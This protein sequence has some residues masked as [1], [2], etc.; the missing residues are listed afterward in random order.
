MVNNSKVVAITPAYNL[1]SSIE[2]TVKEM[3]EYCDEVIV[4]SD[5]STDKTNENARKTKAIV[6]DEKNIRG[7]GNAVIR[8]IEYSKKLNPAYIILIDADGQHLP[9]EIPLFLKKLIEENADMV[10]GSRMKGT[11]KTSTINKIGNFGLKM[12]SFFVSG[13]WSTDTETG[14][15]A[16]N[17]KIYSLNLTSSFYELE[18]E[19]FLRACHEKF[20]ICEVPIIIP[21]AVKGITVKDGFKIG[22][23][24]IYHGFKIR[25]G[26][27]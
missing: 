20:K 17:K 24:K 13:V 27:E 19:M 21:M 12:I 26:M 4:V 23:Y 9:S 1:E 15:R 10:V 25:L 11:L 2:V 7:K 16:F 22:W 3:L 8:G 6:L 18:S 14:F 5:G